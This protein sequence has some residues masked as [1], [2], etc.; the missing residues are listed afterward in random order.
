MAQTGA[1]GLSLE[2][3]VDPFTAVKLVGN[4]VALC[5]NVGPISPLLNGT[6]EMVK[7]HTQRCLDAGFRVI[8]PGCSIAMDS[9]ADNLRAMCATTKASQ[10]SISKGN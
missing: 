9:P 8:Q 1:S 2:Q 4:K 5:G 3:K 7:E 10:K 6:P